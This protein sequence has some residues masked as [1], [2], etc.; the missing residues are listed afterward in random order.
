MKKYNTIKNIL[1]L[2]Y[3]HKGKIMISPKVYQKQ[4]RD[5]GIEGMIISAGDAEEANIVLD[6]LNTIESVLIRIR[7]NIRMDTRAI[8]REYL[9]KIKKEE[10][11]RRSRHDKTKKKGHLMHERDM[12]VTPYEAIE[13]VIDDYLRQITDAKNYIVNYVMISLQEE[14]EMEEYYS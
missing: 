12:K 6:K 4:I 8:R 13:L 2:K 3:I 1:Q 10:Q 7:Y 14:E 5:L 9:K 11:K